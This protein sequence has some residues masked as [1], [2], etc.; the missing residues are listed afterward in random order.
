MKLIFSILLVTCLACTE[1]DGWYGYWIHEGEHASIPNDFDKLLQSQV[2]SRHLRFDAWFSEGCDYDLTVLGSDSTD[3]NKLYGMTDCN[4]SIH[5]HSARFVWRHIGND[6]IEIYNYVYRAGKLV[7]PRKMGTTTLHKK[8][9][10]EI[11]AKNDWYKFRFDDYRD[12][13]RRTV[14]WDHGCSRV[15]LWPWFGGNRTAPNDILIVIYE[16]N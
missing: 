1:P 12:S 3:F 7:T 14:D 9:E 16:Y 6:S 11:W 4:K 8:N 5:D 15:R 13:I 10:Y 2:N